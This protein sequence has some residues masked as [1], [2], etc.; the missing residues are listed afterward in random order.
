MS[1]WIFVVAVVLVATRLCGYIASRCGMPPIVGELIAGILIGPVGIGILAS[2]WHAEV[3]VPAQ[4]VMHNISEIAVMLLMVSVGRELREGLGDAKVKEEARGWAGWLVGSLTLPIVVGVAVAIAAPSLWPYLVGNTVAF[5]LVV[6]VIFTV[7][8][9]PVLAHQVEQ[10]VAF[11]R[12]RVPG[13]ADA[14]LADTAYGVGVRETRRIRGEATLQDDAVR[15]ARHTDDGIA[16]GAHHIDLHGAG[17]EQTRIPVR[18]GGSY[19]IPFGCLVPLGLRNLLVAGRCISSTRAANGSCRV[20]GT[21]LAL[22]QAAGT[23]AARVAADGLDDTRA[24]D[25]TALRTLLKA[26]GAVIDGTR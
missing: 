9:L 25:V 18:E 8:A 22:G 1:T 2:D 7:T 6:A 21:C 23:A 11:L 16:R 13:F 12:D 5:V 19:D 17:T 24:L 4:P 14:V 3:I 20:M 26:Q 10:G 15:E